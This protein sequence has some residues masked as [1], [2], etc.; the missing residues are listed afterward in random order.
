M[1]FAKANKKVLLI[2]ADIRNP[3]VYQF[4]SGKNVDRLGKPTRDKT[5]NGLTEF[6]VDSTIKYFRY[7]QSFVGK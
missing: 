1:I 2:G 3:K 4:Y 6:L 5:N 7:N